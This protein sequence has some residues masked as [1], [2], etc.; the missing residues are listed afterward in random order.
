MSAESAFNG[1]LVV[2]RVEKRK[3]ELGARHDTAEFQLRSWVTVDIHLKKTSADRLIVSPSP[4]LDSRWSF[5]GPP[6]RAST[7]HVQFL[8]Q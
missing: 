8:Q 6:P 1:V 3:L 2:A 7:L 5:S 4:N